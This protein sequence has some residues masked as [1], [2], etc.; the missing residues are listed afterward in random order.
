MVHAP[1][2][3]YNLGW[4]INQTNL[5]NLGFWAPH[6]SVFVIVKKKSYWQGET[7]CPY[8]SAVMPLLA[9]S[10]AQQLFQPPHSDSPG[11]DF[12]LSLI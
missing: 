2:L 11:Y 9:D 12:F 8:R 6:N 10:A 4:S 3:E 1:Y 5:F 7:S